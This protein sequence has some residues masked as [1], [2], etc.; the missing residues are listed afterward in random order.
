V[1]RCEVGVPARLGQ[2]VLLRESALQIILLDEHVLLQHFNR[3][4]FFRRLCC[5]TV[6]GIV[7]TLVRSYVG[8]VVWWYVG[9]L[10]CGMLVCWTGRRR[11]GTHSEIVAQ[12]TMLAMT[13]V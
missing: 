11:L 12:R 2:H 7:G 10:V 3:V 13:T 9:M 6:V 8:M 1:H 5:C 4:Y